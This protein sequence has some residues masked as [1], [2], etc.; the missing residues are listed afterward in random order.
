MS[1]AYGKKGDGGV[2]HP[3]AAAMAQ[4]GGGGGLLGWVVC[5]PAATVILLHAMERAPGGTL[6]KP[7]FCSGSQHFFQLDSSRQYRL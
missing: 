4:P 7:A 6:M 5:A 3:S 1:Y 2:A